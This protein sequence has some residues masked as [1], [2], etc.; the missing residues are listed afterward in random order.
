[1]G[2]DGSVESHDEAQLNAAHGSPYK[3]PYE[4]PKP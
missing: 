4:G 1:V 3:G 2:H